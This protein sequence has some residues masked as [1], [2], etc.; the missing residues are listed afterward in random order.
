MKKKS[1][2]NMLVNRRASFDYHLS[3][4]LTVGMVLSGKKVRATR[5]HR[6]QLKGAYVTIHKGELW[7]NNASFSIKNPNETTVDISPV[8]LLA[9]KKQIIALE[10]AKIAGTSIVPTKMLTAGRHIKLII[11]LGK[12]KK[13][14]DKRETI[15]KRDLEREYRKQKGAR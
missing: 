6:A 5:D 7:L 11:A 2:N 13:R 14:Y 3:D 9:T 12:G 1:N 8:K 4:E 15:K 10:K